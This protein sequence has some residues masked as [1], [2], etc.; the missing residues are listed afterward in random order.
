MLANDASGYAAFV[1]V[2]LFCAA[3]RYMQSTSPVLQGDPTYLMV[4]E[5]ASEL[6]EIGLNAIC[7]HLGCVVPW[8]SAEK[9]FKCPCHGSQYNRDG[10]VVRGPAPLSLP[11]CHVAVR[12]LLSTVVKRVFFS[13]VH[14]YVAL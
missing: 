5:D 11:L 7:T 12:S 9:K 13:M 10:K 6:R 1:H 3:K 2:I 4:K 8:N 14:V